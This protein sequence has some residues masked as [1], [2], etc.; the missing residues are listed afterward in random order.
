MDITNRNAQSHPA[1]CYSYYSA[2]AK[3]EHFSPCPC[4][5]ISRDLWNKIAERLPL[6]GSENM[7]KVSS[8]LP[9]T[10]V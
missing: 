2:S 7:G 4:I 5:Y 6:Q 8:C 9:L 3:P 1:E 10:V